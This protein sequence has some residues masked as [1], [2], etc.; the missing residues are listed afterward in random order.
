MTVSRD[1]R[2]CSSPPTADRTWVQRAAAAAQA[3]E[4]ATAASI[5]AAEALRAAER[6]AVLAAESGSSTDPVQWPPIA[7][8]N[9]NRFFLA[10]EYPGLEDGVYTVP[11]LL[12]RGVDADRPAATGLLQ[13]WKTVDPALRRAQAQGTDT[14]TVFWK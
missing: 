7:C 3:A 2:A 9:G 5:A 8:G 6:A 11:A 4:A 1:Q 10:R 12:T 14:T 13:G